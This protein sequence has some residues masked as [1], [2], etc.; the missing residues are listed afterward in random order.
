[1]TIDAAFRFR[2]AD[3]RGTLVDGV[4]RVATRDAALRELRRRQLWPLTVEPVSAATGASDAAPAS[5][6]TTVFSGSTRRRAVAEWVRTLA[7]LLGAG[8][9]ID[10][11]LRVAHA[12]V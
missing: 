6:M 8:A 4:L 12:Q 11:A 1:M 9:P 5:S 3:D 7:T 2:A 10:R